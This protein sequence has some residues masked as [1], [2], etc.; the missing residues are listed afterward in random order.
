MQIEFISIDK[1]IPYASN[2]RYNQ[3]AVAKV[4]ASIKEF[5]WQQPIV[6]DS[7]MVVIAG[8]TRL[9]AAKQLK[10]DKVPVHIAAN[11]TPA[12]IK[13]YRIADNRLHEDAV[14]DNELLAIELSDLKET[15]FDLELIGFNPRELNQLLNGQDYDNAEEVKEF[16]ATDFENFKHQC[17]KCG[18]EWND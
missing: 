15:G 10:L 14:W 2:P 5:G 18:F 11:L 8:H 4:A 1:L 3:V 13:A 16:A 7:E 6:A 17:P 9:L 12:Q